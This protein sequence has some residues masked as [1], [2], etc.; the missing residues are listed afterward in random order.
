MSRIRAST[1]LGTLVA[2][3]A[4]MAGI[5]TLSPT[6]ASATPY[7]SPKKH[8]PPPPPT[9][10]VDRGVVKYGVTVRATG[11]RYAA[12]EKVHVTVVYRPKGSYHWRTVKTA[13]V[14]AD[15]KGRFVIRVKMYRPGLVVIKAKGT[16]SRQ[17]A[18]AA[19]Y[20]IDRKK[21]HG[22]WSVRPASY[23]AAPPPRRPPTG[24]RPSRPP[25]SACWRSPAARWSPGRPS[26]GVAGPDRASGTPHRRS[27]V[28]RSFSFAVARA[29]RNLHLP[30]IN[31]NLDGTSRGANRR[32][33][34]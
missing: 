21:G 32:F 3:L 31:A 25:A 20:V 12:R 27:A 7:A 23:T 17:Y 4:M 29:F 9:L 26:G 1:V 24:P 11:R 5:V 22:Y 10:T 18:A 8:Y 34:Q 33:Q 6:A 13:V 15:H 16:Q 14:R 30:S 28:G 2:T 19:V